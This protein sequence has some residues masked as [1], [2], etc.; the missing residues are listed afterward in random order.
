MDY[1]Q[2]HAEATSQYDQGKE[3]V[4]TLPTPAGQKYPPGTRV[5]I[6]DVLPRYQSHFRSGC[7]ATVDY[8]YAHAYGGGD[9]KSYSLTID[10]HG[11]S[12]WY[13]ED[14]LTPIDDE[15]TAG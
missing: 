5:R 15:P 1:Q 7:N 6:A 14:Q 10:G 8:T 12:A 2:R 13:E 3:R 4:K 11:S 9:V